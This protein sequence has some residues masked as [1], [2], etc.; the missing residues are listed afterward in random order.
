M[1]RVFISSPYTNG[2]KDWNVLAQIVT[3]NKLIDLGL[4][5]FT[6]LLHHYLEVQKSR[7]SEVWLDLMI[8]WMLECDAVLRLPG[9]SEG[10]DEEC[11]VA[12]ENNIP[13]FYSLEELKTYFRL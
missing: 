2:N 9:E 7:S 1:K 3:A 6:P 8:D 13:V 5:P 10:A 12:E 11:R 4:S